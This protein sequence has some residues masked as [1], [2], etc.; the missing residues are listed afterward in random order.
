MVY[1]LRDSSVIPPLS[2]R[3]GNGVVTVRGRVW[4]MGYRREAKGERRGNAAKLLTLPKERFRSDDPSALRILQQ[5]LFVL[6]FV[7]LWLAWCV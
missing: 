1:G 4:A 6:F 3:S 7:L 2:L 5:T